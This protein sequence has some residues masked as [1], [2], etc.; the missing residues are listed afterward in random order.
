MICCYPT[1][2]EKTKKL[3]VYLTGI[4]ENENQE[5]RDRPHGFKY[6]HLFIVLDGEGRIFCEGKEAVLRRGDIFF[7]KK[8]TPHRYMPKKEPFH[9]MWLTFDGELADSVLSYYGID[10]FYLAE[11]VC[12][13]IVSK[14]FASLMHSARKNADENTLSADL[15]K[16]I[17]EAFSARKTFT[18]DLGCAVAYI[19][20]NYASEISLSALAKLCHMSSFAFCREFKRQ[21]SIT[22]FEFLKRE[23]VKVA[24]EL[25]IS[26]RNLKI[27]EIAE[28]CGFNDT[29]YFCRTFRECA[30]KSPAE[31]R[32]EEL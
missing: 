28:R 5:L 19:E 30:G 23:R 31:F 25:L 26:Q 1:T 4:G 11:G 17:T 29:G 7:I 3:P 6:H 9:D 22:A 13:D 2:D 18:K 32:R 20:E 21:Y 15:Y 12:N 14:S 16:L 10:R 24:K 27:S 8:D